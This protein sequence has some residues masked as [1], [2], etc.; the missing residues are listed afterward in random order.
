MKTKD[1]SVSENQ[2]NFSF[3]TVLY[4][5]ASVVALIGVALLIDNIYIF[6]TTIDQYVTQGYPVADVTKSLIPAQLL[7]GIFDPL[8]VYGGIAFIL[9]GVGAANKKISGLITQAKVE[10]PD[11]VAEEGVVENPGQAQFYN[12]I[13][14]RVDEDKQEEVKSLLEESFAKQTDG[15]FDKEYITQFTPK[16]LDMIKPEYMAEVKNVMEGF[17]LNL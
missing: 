10:S 8:A 5:A 11:D 2:R 16:I 1:K 13:L 15:T 14:E 12:F 9:F 7:P 17:A 6:K 3:S 4:I